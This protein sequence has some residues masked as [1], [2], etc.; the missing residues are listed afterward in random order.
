MNHQVHHW[1]IFL[2][3]SLSKVIFSSSMAPCFASG[4]GVRTI[5]QIFR[6]LTMSKPPALTHNSH[7][8]LDGHRNSDLWSVWIQ[9]NIYFLNIYIRGAPK[10]KTHVAVGSVATK[11]MFGPQGHKKTTKEA[12]GRKKTGIEAL[13]NQ[14][15][16]PIILF[17]PRNCIGFRGYFGR[18]KQELLKTT[19]VRM[20]GANIPLYNYTG[21]QS[22]PIYQLGCISK[23]EF[24]SHFWKLFDKIVR[25]LISTKYGF[26][27]VWP[28]KVRVFPAIGCTNWQ[29]YCIQNHTYISAI[30]HLKLPLTQIT[31]MTWYIKKYIHS[32]I[33]IYTYKQIHVYIYIYMYLYIYI[34]I[35]I[36][37]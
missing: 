20:T 9:L 23:L 28:W 18:P 36:Y 27:M 1:V 24:S 3:V 12:F 35:H 26:D 4:N 19:T 2:G 6:R 10:I 25:M 31:G 17:S 16:T 30:L 8:H 22:I 14:G 21:L 33:Y 7:G 32:I 34:Y 37:R 13:R 15:F 11:S 5:L 29:V